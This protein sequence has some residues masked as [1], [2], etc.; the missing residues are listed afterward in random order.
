MYHCRSRK[1]SISRTGSRRGLSWLHWDDVLM[2]ALISWIFF[3]LA[4][5]SWKLLGKY[6]ICMLYFLIEW[7]IDDW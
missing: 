3:S 1:F 4:L 6:L 7:M 2:V 5:I